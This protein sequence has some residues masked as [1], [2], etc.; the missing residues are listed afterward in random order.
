MQRNNYD[1]LIA[2]DADLSHDPMLIPEFIKDLETNS[3]V[4]GSDMSGGRNEMSLLKLIKFF[5]NK[6]IKSVLKINL[7]EFTT[8]YRGLI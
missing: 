1:L 6:L 2:L 8:S 7:D 5:N 3:F 4:I